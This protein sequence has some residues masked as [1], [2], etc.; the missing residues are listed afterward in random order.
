[1]LACCQ[2]CLGQAETSVFARRCADASQIA[3]RSGMLGREVAWRLTPAG[4]NDIGAPLLA[5]AA[6]EPKSARLGFVAGMIAEDKLHSF[7]RLLFRATRGNMFLKSASVGTVVDPTTTEKVEKAVFVVFFAGERARSKILKVCA[8]AC[9]SVS[10]HTEVCWHQYAGRFSN[11]L[12]K[13]SI[14]G[15]T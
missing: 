4:G 15:L 13:T 8:A 9:P 2:S 7:E 10:T 14:Q 11:R 12:M 1:M 6:P 3:L 5:E